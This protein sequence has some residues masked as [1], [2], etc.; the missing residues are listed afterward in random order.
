MAMKLWRYVLALS[1][2]WLFIA[3]SA[4][5]QSTSPS[6]VD[7]P[8]KAG[9]TTQESSKSPAKRKGGVRAVSSR[10]QV[11]AVQQALKDK[12]YDPGEVDG[13]MGPKTRAAVRDFQRK[14]GLRV[15]GRIDPATV[16][17]LGIDSA[18][19]A[20]SATRSG[21]E[22]KPTSGAASGPAAS[23]AGAN[24]PAAGVQQ[25]GEPKK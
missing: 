3:S 9:T 16:A 8:T 15:T 21:A 11:T 25:L 4:T 5:A 7:S 19:T 1:V 6:S 10:E 2:A 20:G 22:V 14:E 13:A 23:P 24:P 12:G 18:K 17:K